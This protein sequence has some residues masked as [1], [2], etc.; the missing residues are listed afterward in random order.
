MLGSNILGSNPRSLGSI[1]AMAFGSR[2][3]DANIL[4]SRPAVAAAMAF[5]S[6]R[7]LSSLGSLSAL[8]SMR[9]AIVFGSIPAMAFGSRPMEANILGSRPAVAAAM[10]FGSVRALRSFGSLKALGSMR[11]A[12]VFGSIPAMAFAS[13]P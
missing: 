11:A 3:M 10:A 6:V 9:A 5:G 1:P 12:I 4:G 13:S 8:G 7:A 2:P